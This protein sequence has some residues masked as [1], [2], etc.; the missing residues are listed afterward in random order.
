METLFVTPSLIP[1]PPHPRLGPV[2]H[3]LIMG[4]FF[5]DIDFG[6]ERKQQAYKAVFWDF[7]YYKVIILDSKRGRGVNDKFICEIFEQMTFDKA[8]SNRTQGLL[9]EG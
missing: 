7:F 2:R 3:A 1:P 9:G 6:F 5:L 4:A 8:M